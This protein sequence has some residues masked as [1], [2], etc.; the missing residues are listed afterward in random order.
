MATDYERIKDL[1][2]GTSFLIADG[3]RGSVRLGTEASTVRAMNDV[4]E[5]PSAMVVNVGE[6]LRRFARLRGV[7]ESDREFSLQDIATIIGNI[8]HVGAWL[9]VEKGVLSP[10]IKAAA[11]PGRGA[12]FSFADT[13]SAGVIGTMRKHGMR[14]PD[15]LK[16][17]Q[18]LFTEKPKKR[19]AR[20][21]T[22]AERS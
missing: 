10:S 17:V 13:F 21:R 6:A 4:A 18:P 14:R 19:T 9:L 8:S 22:T 5:F 3:I 15:L 11:G 1:L 12:V 7:G 2:G 20:R 16:K